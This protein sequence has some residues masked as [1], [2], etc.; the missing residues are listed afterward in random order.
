VG[1]AAEDECAAQ[2][3]EQLLLY[4]DYLPHGFRVESTFLFS[5]ESQRMG[6]LRAIEQEIA[7][8]VGQNFDSFVFYFGMTAG[9]LEPSVCEF[10]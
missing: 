4:L 10:L 7:R 9:I 8:T 5:S 2:A 3:K 6:M 1:P